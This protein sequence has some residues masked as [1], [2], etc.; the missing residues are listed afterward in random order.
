MN[1]LD[2]LK[3][4]YRECVDKQ[5]RLKT[6]KEQALQRNKLIEEKYNIRNEEQL[7]HL[8]DEL[9]QRYNEKIQ[10]ASIKLVEIKQSLTPYESTM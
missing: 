5:I 1:E 6:L 10:E 3:A 2:M 4:Q 7:K 8:V 9:Q